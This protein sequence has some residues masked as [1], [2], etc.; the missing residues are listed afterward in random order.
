MEHRSRGRA[1]LQ[2]ALAGLLGATAGASAIFFLHWRSD[3]GLVDGLPVRAPAET[4]RE[5]AAAAEEI[6]AGAAVPEKAE[7]A[8]EA[9]QSARESDGERPGAEPAGAAQE[10]RAE[11]G[12]A[13]GGRD[14]LELLAMLDGEGR[15]A[16][17]KLAKENAALR[18]RNAELE[19]RNRKLGE[20]L[21]EAMEA[22]DLRKL[23][24]LPEATRAAE[25][26]PEGGKVLGVDPDLELVA[27]DLGERDGMRYGLPM[28]VIR[29]GRPVARVRVV[30]VRE[31]M[32]GAVVEDTSAG[33]YP[34]EGDRAVPTRTADSEGT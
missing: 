6:G 11:E 25:P 21:A 30:D 18:K 33:A 32:A 22:L 15:R 3:C 1:W 19:K 14:N 28:T 24:A 34:R 10:A 13:Q 4:L 17:E 2:L 29:D 12:G 20:R 5:S 16:T 27:V 8:A 23:G 9:A 26:K 31:R 7:T